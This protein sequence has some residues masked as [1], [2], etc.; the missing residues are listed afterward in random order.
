M[1]KN[2]TGFTLLEVTIIVIIITVLSSVSL[3]GYGNFN[4]NKR[5]E[6]AAT[7]LISTLELAKKKAVAIDKNLTVAG[8][9]YSSCSLT[10][11]KV[12]LN[13]ATAYSLVVNI[14]DIGSCP[15]SSG[16]QDVTITSHTIP[17]GLTISPTTGSVTF[18][19]RTGVATGLSSISILHTNL[20]KT[21]TITIEAS[22]IIE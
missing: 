9:D 4:Q 11:Y 22:G 3:A 21:K 18:E 14:C 20:N 8:S 1:V 10:N 7:E 2:N 12:S 5:L 15:L 13:S 16:C 6:G 17:S 19:T